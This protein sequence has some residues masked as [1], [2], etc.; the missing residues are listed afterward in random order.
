MRS[1]HW[2]IVSLLASAAAAQ[3]V[4]SDVNS[5]GPNPSS[6]PT[7]GVRAGA[8]AFYVADDGVAGRELWRTDGTAAGTI[9]LRDIAPGAASGNPENLTAVGSV[10]YFTATDPATGLEIWRTDGTPAGTMLVADLEPGTAG[11]NPLSLFAAGSQ[12]YFTATF[13]DAVTGRGRELYR[14]DGTPAGTLLVADVRP[15]PLSG[16]GSDAT[17][18]LLGARV[19]FPAT[20]GVNGRELWSTD[21]TSAGTALLADVHPT[22]SSNPGHLTAVGGRVYFTAN[23]GSSGVE[24]W[25]TDGTFATTVQVADLAAGVAG[26]APAALTALGGTLLFSADDGTGFGREP[27]RTDGTVGGTVRL[28]D[29]APGGAGSGVTTIVVAGGYGWLL[30]N[31][32]GGQTLLVRTDGTVAGTATVL[33]SYAGMHDLTAAGNGVVFGTNLDA[34]HDEPWAAAF[35]VPPA[36]LFDVNPGTAPSTPSAFAVLGGNLCFAA[37][38]PGVGG[39]LFAGPLGGGVANLLADVAP[40]RTS[41]TSDPQS[42]VLF[43]DRVWFTADDGVHGRE[44]WVADG[45]DGPAQLFLDLGPG[46][47]PSSP[48]WLTP[49]DDLLYF[50]ADDGVSGT[51]LWVTDGTPSG[52]HL[53]ADLMPGPGSSYPVHMTAVN[54]Q[55]VF[56]AIDN[57]NF[58]TNLFVTDGTAAG[59][60]RLFDFNSQGGTALGPVVASGPRVFLP[61]YLPSTGFEL[62]V[63]D[64]TPAGTH[65]VVELEPGVNSGWPQIAFERPMVAWNGGVLFNGQTIADAI[66]VWF[67]DGTAAGTTQVASVAPGNSSGFNGWFTRCGPYVY[68]QGWDAFQG[69]GYGVALWRT[70]GTAAGTMVVP[71]Q[72]N[73]GQP[74]NLL[75]LGDVLLFDVYENT[76]GRELWRT[77]GSAA[78]TFRISDIGPTVMSGSFG[79]GARVGNSGVAVFAAGTASID[80]E[81]WRTDGTLGGTWQVADLNP[82]LGA[83]SNPDSFVGDGISVFFVADNGQIGREPWRVPVAAIGAA[84]AERVGSGCVGTAGRRPRIGTYGLPQ[85]GNAQFAIEVGNGAPFAAAFLLLNLGTT[86]AQPLGGGCTEYVPLPAVSNLVLTSAT[87][88]G[89][90]PF[91]LPSGLAFVGLPLSAQYWVL[92]PQGSYQGFASLSDGLRLVIGQ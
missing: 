3:S 78:G 63:T 92:D 54:G 18:A 23:D 21:G 90:Y 35:G 66:E 10:L 29:L 67:S 24:L 36:R 69:P 6:N 81:L 11:S 72:P 32:G 80:R 53:V 13:G 19:A 30:A 28:A 16:L 91:A 70:D 40:Q 15:G 1:V 48:R 59:T 20:D 77:D 58:N 41:A 64:T 57:Q 5:Q 87:G 44:L 43:L 12:L 33:G 22:A 38:R 82:G 83:G 25:R 62:W 37:F 60:Q 27:F 7:G 85:V 47:Y 61:A 65:L 79:P 42:A 14:T 50:A 84:G 56:R 86:I 73:N 4:I 52:T 55:V 17:L 2:S 51:E 68:F 45:T 46:G 39:E 49:V 26:S 9:L 31:D 89:S 74:Q 88:T 34:A 71:G 76:T 75:A 8:F